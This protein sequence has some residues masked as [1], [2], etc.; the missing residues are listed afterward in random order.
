[1]KPSPT[2]ILTIKTEPA[3]RPRREDDFDLFCRKIAAEQ[4]RRVWRAARRLTQ[5]PCPAAVHDIRVA[6]RRL[7][8]ALRQFR[9]RLPLARVHRRTLVWFGRGFGRVRELDVRDE[10]L[11][12]RIAARP[13]PGLEAWRE[14]GRRRRGTSLNRAVARLDA[15]RFRA[16]ARRLWEMLAAEGAPAP[17]ARDCAAGRIYAA[18]ARVQRRLGRP[19]ETFGPAKL[20][21]LRIA[22]KHLRYTC[23]FFAPLADERFKG[24][25]RYWRRYQ[26]L[27]GRHHDARQ[28][29]TRF[30]GEASR[31]TWGGPE[32]APE[33]AFWQGR[34][35]READ[36]SRGEFL[37]TWKS[38]PYR[39][40][41]F[42]DEL[43]SVFGGGDPAGNDAHTSTRGSH[44]H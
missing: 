32:R 23:E 43:A 12:Q 24:W 22:C 38:L 44:G 14:D 34:L 7:R 41:E 6:L 29:L 33:L 19:A 18:A 20:H 26:D 30:A 5:D 9:D 36:A 8:V 27:L 4:W 13:S 21:R 2:S 17:L 28:L 16:A 10:M 11:A 39:L 40:P 3:F 15:G 37:R 1:M 42:Y 35:E 25:V 31:P